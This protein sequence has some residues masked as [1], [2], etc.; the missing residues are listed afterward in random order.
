[1]TAQKQGLFRFPAFNETT[2]GVN[3][4]RSVCGYQWYPEQQALVMIELPEN[5]SSSVDSQFALVCHDLIQYLGLWDQAANI[6]FLLRSDGYFSPVSDENEVGWFRRFHPKPRSD[7]T[8]A[9]WQSIGG[10]TRLIQDQP[11]T[12]VS[13]SLV[14]W[15]LKQP[16]EPWDTFLDEFQEAVG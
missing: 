12:T 14:E 5:E 1:M 7:G 8:V 6:R 16:L 4:G 15:W 11:V 2:K 3:E 10:Q 9:S 13:R